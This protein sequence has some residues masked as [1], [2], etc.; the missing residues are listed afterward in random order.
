MFQLLAILAFFIL[1]LSFFAIG[2]D[3]FGIKRI[4]EDS[5]NSTS[6]DKELEGTD[7]DLSNKP[8]SS[9]EYE[10]SKNKTASE[11][12]SQISAK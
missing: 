1:G 4:K 3:D 7:A 8:S 5:N 11:S 6:K 9:K 10:S 12:S 2:K